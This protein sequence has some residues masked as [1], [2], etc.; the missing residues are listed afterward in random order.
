MRVTEKDLQGVIK[1]LNIIA[2]SP[3]ESY[4]RGEDGQLRANPGNYH[5][6]RA[7]GGYKLHRMCNEGG[8][9]SDV[10]FCGYTTKRE[11]YKLI[12]AYISGIY[13]KEGGVWR[14]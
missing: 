5:L 4:T 8:G 10:L 14:G 3:L 12:Q 7:Y 13:A 9:T 1:R 2:D 6:D 11:L